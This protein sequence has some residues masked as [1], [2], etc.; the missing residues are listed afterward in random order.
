MLEVGV[1]EHQ[2]Q[3]EQVELAAEELEHQVQQLHKE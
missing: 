2:E 3:V 1:E